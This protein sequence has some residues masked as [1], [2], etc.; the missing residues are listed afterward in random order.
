MKCQKCDRP[1]TYHITELASGTPVE[2]HFCEEHAREYLS[3]SQTPPS[4]QMTQIAEQMAE[5][6][7]KHMVVGKAAEELKRLDEQTCPYCGISFHD[8]RH[9]GRLGCPYDYQA[10]REQLESLILN[11]HS[12]T[13]HQGKRPSKGAEAATR[14]TELIR[15]RREIKEAVECEEYE[16]ASQLRD[17]IREIEEAG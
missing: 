11:I 1:A 3:G 6:L 16:R 12:E 17:Q 14:R 2:L 13:R 15:L 5:H 7:V 10:F 9:Q 4:D 8:F